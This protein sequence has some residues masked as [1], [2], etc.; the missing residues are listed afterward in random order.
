MVPRCIVLALFLSLSLSGPANAEPLRVIS[1]PVASGQAFV[2]C[3]FDGI[4]ED[5]FLDTGSAMTLLVSS[6]ELSGKTNAGT[7]HFKGATGISQ[8]GETIQIHSAVLDSVEFENLKIGRIRRDLQ[9]Q[10]ALGIDLLGRRPFSLNF[11]FKPSL[12]LDPKA[13]RKLF[14]TLEVGA[15]H[16]F[17]VPLTIGKVDSRALWDSGAGI[18]V[19]DESFIHTHPENFKQTDDFETATDG[20]GGSIPVKTFRAK[21]IKIG[22]RT[23]RNSRVIATDL[24]VLRA[25]G[26]PPVRA[27]IGFNLI[28]K[29]DWYFDAK[30]TK[31][32]VR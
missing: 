22:H 21:V 23:F 28:R 20:T 8:Q 7:F 12:H 6:E 19:V 14:T 16:L 18:T 5:C 9:V 1:G 26:N 13:P 3:T 31:W 30:Q 27:V 2:F 17:T 11:R 24:S 29:C 32:S 15:H 25:N 4:R 10:S